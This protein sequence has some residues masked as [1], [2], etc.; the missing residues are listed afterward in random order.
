MGS[1]LLDKIGSIFQFAAKNQ[2]NINNVLRYLD[3]Y[4]YVDPNHEHNVE[5]LIRAITSLHKAVGLPSD[6][7]ISTQTMKILQLPRCGCK[8]VGFL[9]DNVASLPK[10]GK[11]RLTYFIKSYPGSVKK[12]QWFAWFREAFDSG[13]A[14][15]NL[16]FTQVFT[17]AEADFII[18]AGQ[19]PAD[20]FDSR[21]GVLAWCE[22]PPIVNYLGK[23]HSK[24]DADELWGIN[25]L[26]PNVAAHEIVGH[27]C[28]L[29]HTDVP[30]SLMNPF[31]AAQIAKPQAHDK[32]EL[33]DRYGLPL[34]SPTT[35]PVVPPTTPTGNDEITIT[36]KGRISDI[37]ASSGF[38][39][40]RG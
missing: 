38:R 29:S 30:G 31:Y 34:S 35:P 10:W 7:T 19:G 16:K 28:G 37:Q 1:N 17:A 25:I 9:T 11:N 13:E 36:I 32:K 12:D 33:V 2:E 26:V 24:F 4:G 5:D 27:G 18:E 6:G 23:I 22:L 14:V 20:Q 15:C 3:K 21:G 40:Y 8:D 39:I